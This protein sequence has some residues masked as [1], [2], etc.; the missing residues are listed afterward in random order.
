[1]RSFSYHV[2]DILSDRKSHRYRTQL[3]ELRVAL[4]LFSPCIFPQPFA[5]QISP[6]VFFESTFQVKHHCLDGEL[7]KLSRTT[8]SLLFHNPTQVVLSAILF[9]EILHVLETPKIY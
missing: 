8:W 3:S 1:M 9:Y 2:R 7:A 4:K 6:V 5:F